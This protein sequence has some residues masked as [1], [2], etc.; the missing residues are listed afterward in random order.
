MSPKRGNKRLNKSRIA[1]LLTRPAFQSGCGCACVR[2]SHRSPPPTTQ[3]RL[4]YSI[5]APRPIHTGHG[6]ECVQDWVGRKKFV[7]N[8]TEQTNCHTV[9]FS[10]N[11]V[12]QDR[13]RLSG[14]SVT[15][16]LVVTRQVGRRMLDGFRRGGWGRG[17]T[18]PFF[19]FGGGSLSQFSTWGDMFSKLRSPNQ[20]KGTS[21]PQCLCTASL[22]VFA[23]HLNKR[24]PWAQT[25]WVAGDEQQ[26][27]LR[28]QHSKHVRRLRVQHRRSGLRGTNQ[29][30]T[31]VPTQG[32]V[33]LFRLRGWEQGRL[34]AY[35]HQHQH[36]VRWLAALCLLFC[37][38]RKSLP[39]EQQTNAG[40]L[41]CVFI[42]LLYKSNAWPTQQ[43][44]CNKPTQG[45]LVSKDLYGVVNLWSLSFSCRSVS[46]PPEP[47]IGLE[48]GWP[49]DSALISIHK[50]KAT[51]MSFSTDA[52]STSS[53]DEANHIQDL[54]SLRKFV[55]TKSIRVGVVWNGAKR[56]WQTP[57]C[58]GWV[59]VERILPFCS[60]MIRNGEWT[61]KR[62]K[63]CVL[64]GFRCSFQ[65]KSCFFPKRTSFGLPENIFLRLW[66][67][68][69]ATVFSS[70]D[71]LT[72]PW[73]C[74][75]F[76]CNS[77]VSSKKKNK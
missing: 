20:V 6:L 47:Q 31:G 5:F 32:T 3:P 69:K 1:R 57:K 41:S 39:Q 24:I 28:Q 52:W 12:A 46:P 60:S 56:R 25:V 10:G 9:Q 61:T 62:Y 35:S 34:E 75:K 23:A 45:A 58:H 70:C 16:R 48:R 72:L 21:H 38:T 54:H 64:F 66:T 29:Q 8:Q 51:Q 76:S 50:C 53:S 67:E 59:G 37:P 68:L 18:S 43:P 40:S 77:R 14:S 49:L 36:V 27:V 55:L 33:H 65:K 15:S 71:L 19:F 13:G 26:G 2:C 4:T 63:V 7:P 22:F 44:Q 42:S 17:S 11:S 73:A 30:Q 74:F